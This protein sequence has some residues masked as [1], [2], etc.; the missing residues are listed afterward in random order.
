MPNVGTLG[1][2]ALAILKQRFDRAAEQGKHAGMDPPVGPFE[3]DFLSSS[4]FLRI[5]LLRL[6][7]NL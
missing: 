7:M 1:V 2:D 3:M 4:F 6:D 5:A